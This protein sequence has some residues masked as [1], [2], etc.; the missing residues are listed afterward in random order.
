MGS[1][2]RVGNDSEIHPLSHPLGATNT[3]EDRR[4]PYKFYRQVHIS[5]ADEQNP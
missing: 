5:I 2:N 4:K 1:I 3:E